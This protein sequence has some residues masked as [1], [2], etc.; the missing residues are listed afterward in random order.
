MKKLATLFQESYREFY[1]YGADDKTVKGV[2]VRTIT[3]L[4]MFGAISI[5]L[6]ALTVAIGD[7]IKI[8]F[9]T[10]ANQ[11]VYYLFGPE[12]G[13]GRC[14]VRSLSVPEAAAPVEGSG[15]GTDGFPDLQRVPGNPVAEHDVRA[16]VF[17]PASHE[18]L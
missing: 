8:G 12:R 3:T 9:S 18:G 2:Q 1:V 17:R 15:G 6:G 7:Y 5:I 14:T 11:F 16:G 10:I 13:S 4:G